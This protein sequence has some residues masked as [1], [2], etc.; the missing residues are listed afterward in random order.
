MVD[1]TAFLNKARSYLRRHWIIYLMLAGY[2][3]LIILQAVGFNAWLPKC[4]ITEITGYECMGCGLNR[5]AIHLIRL[6]FS[7]AFASN[8]LIYLYVPLIIGWITIDFYKFKGQL[9]EQQP[10]EQN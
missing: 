6:D 4:L 8:P 2:A 1:I 5:A 10:N 3:V 9:T 7:E